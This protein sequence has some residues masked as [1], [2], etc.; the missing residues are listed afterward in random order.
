MNVRTRQNR[1]ECCVRLGYA[2]IGNRPLSRR[3][4]SLSYSIMTGSLDSES[5]L[6]VVVNE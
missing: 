1:G 5:P 4:I 6:R 3:H 2:R